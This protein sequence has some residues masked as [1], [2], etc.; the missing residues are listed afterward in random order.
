MVGRWVLLDARA[1]LGGDA[2][3]NG[4][5]C[6]YMEFSFWGKYFCFLLSSQY[7]IELNK[8]W[9]E[10]PLPMREGA[11]MAHLWEQSQARPLLVCH[12]SQQ[13]AAA[14]LCFILKLVSYWKQHEMQ[15]RT[16]VKT[17]SLSSQ[18]RMMKT[19]M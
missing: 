10:P 13:A 5:S 15:N 2:H 9:I 12:P 7:P 1:M 3:N 11:C 19:L 8:A 6:T 17:K 16:E 18:F 14:L 4:G